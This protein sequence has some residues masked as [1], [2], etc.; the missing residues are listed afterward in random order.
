VQISDYGQLRLSARALF[1]PQKIP[2]T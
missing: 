1:S 2:D